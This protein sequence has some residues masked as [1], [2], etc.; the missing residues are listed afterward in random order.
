MHKITVYTAG[1]DT[2]NQFTTPP[3]AR[4][5]ADLVAIHQNGNA[6]GT[7]GTVSKSMT[8]SSSGNWVVVAFASG[9]VIID[10]GNFNATYD[11]WK[12]PAAFFTAATTVYVDI[13]WSA[14]FYDPGTAFVGGVQAAVRASL[15]AGSTS[16]EYNGLFMGSDY[17]AP[18]YGYAMTASG[19]IPA[20][21]LTSGQTVELRCWQN[22][23]GSQTILARYG[24]RTHHAA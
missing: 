15:G 11:C 23:G 2:R 20:V 13:V 8:H 1:T 24:V 16:A 12:P 18:T 3:D 10:D 9:D 14:A 19:I 4:Q 21:P 17:N 7:G 6:A 22:T 5:V